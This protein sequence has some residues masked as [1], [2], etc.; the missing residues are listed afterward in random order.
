[1][2][3]L[4]L[5]NGMKCDNQARVVLIRLLIDSSIYLFFFKLI[6]IFWIKYN[7]METKKKKTHNNQEK[8]WFIYNTKFKNFDFKCICVK[9]LIKLQIPNPNYIFHAMNDILYNYL[10]WIWNILF[11]YS[12]LKL[13]FSSLRKSIFVCL[14]D[15]S[16]WR[17][18]M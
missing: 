12:F 10:N 2:C 15:D 11:W 8:Q 17:I 3:N 14:L 6:S 9:L 7:M 1:M 16:G 4:V 18:Y 13:R 5:T